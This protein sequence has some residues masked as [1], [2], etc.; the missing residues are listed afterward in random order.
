MSVRLRV[1]VVDDNKGVA[2]T[3]SLLVQDCGHEVATA[4]DG[5]RALEAAAH[6][7]P[8]IILLD[9]G[10]PGID[11]FE[12]TRMLRKKTELANVLIIAITGHADDAHRRQALEAGFDSFLVKP[13]DGTILRDFLVAIPH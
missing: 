8:H 7:R 3:L 12:L 2:D 9:I 4:Y 6:F 1:L 5:P 10:L 13:V 11:G